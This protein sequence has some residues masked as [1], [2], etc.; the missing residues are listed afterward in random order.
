MDTTFASPKNGI[1]AYARDTNTLPAILN[2]SHIFHE[3][4]L[5]E[6]GQATFWINGQTYQAGPHT[7]VAISCLEEHN[8][9]IQAAPYRRQVLSVTEQFC[10]GSIREPILVSFFLSRSAQFCP[11]IPLSCG[12]FRRLS[13]YMSQIIAEFDQAESFW[14][15][16][17]QD[18]LEEIVLCL[19]RYRSDLFLQ[20]N[21]HASV[22]V[23]QVQRYIAEHY[24]E[25]ITLDDLAQTCFLSKYYLSHIFQK[26][27]GYGI[28]KYL[29]L[30]RI[31]EAKQ[32]LE[33]TE[34]SITEICFSVGYNDIN[35]FIRLFRRSEKTSPLQY[36]KLLRANPKHFH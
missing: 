34:L 36:R 23:F 24:A 10:I 5:I 26:A 28:Q 12:V 22:A 33:N 14:M 27:T 8:M 15:L 20:E 9:Q 17:V 19:Y 1:S 7:L 16:H 35:H 21:C 6:E 29:Q 4:I 31:N 32:L 25:K 30:Y 18:L 13:H 2:H 11:V 3:L